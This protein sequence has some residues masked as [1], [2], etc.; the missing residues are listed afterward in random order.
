MHISNGYSLRGSAGFVI[1]VALHTGVAALALAGLRLVDAPRPPPAPIVATEI[2]EAIKPPPIELRPDTRPEQ[3]AADV[4]TPMFD[5]YDIPTVDTSTKTVTDDRPQGPAIDP[6]L[7]KPPVVV[8]PIGITR[9]ASLDA[10][11]ARDFEAPYP[12][13]SQRMGETGTVVVRVVIGVDG[14][15]LRATVARSSGFERLDAAALRQ[16]LAKWRFIPA[17]KG[18]TAVEAERE[19]PVT[20]RLLEG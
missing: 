20:F 19:V 7:L 2:P 1:T 11:Y 16:A 13:A 8:E 5:I 10:R 17:L 14:R 3:I 6:A 9:G 12:S 18:G 4:V 15:V